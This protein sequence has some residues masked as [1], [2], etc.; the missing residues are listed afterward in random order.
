MTHEHQP[1]LF[2]APDP[3]ALARRGDPTTSKLAAEEIVDKLGEDQEFALRCVRA[4]PGPTAR[5]LDEEFAPTNP[6]K[7]W[8]RISELASKGLIVEAGTRRCRTS[9]RMARTWKIAEKA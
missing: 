6:G 9:G 5:E 1:N 8:K 7:L 2:D 4:R 3:R